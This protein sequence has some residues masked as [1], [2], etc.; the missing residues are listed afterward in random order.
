MRMMVH[1]AVGCWIRIHLNYTSSARACG[2][3]T[4]VSPT[5]AVTIYQPFTNTPTI[6]QPFNQQ[7]PTSTGT[8]I[9]QPTNSFCHGPCHG[10]SWRWSP[11]RSPLFRRSQS[12][13]SGSA[14]AAR[15]WPYGNRAKQQPLVVSHWYSSIVCTA[16]LNAIKLCGT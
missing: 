16:N 15:G 7:S 2:I 12:P 1:M 3:F 14:A 13:F 9:P 11:P 8:N 4:E 5:I 10:C 6:H